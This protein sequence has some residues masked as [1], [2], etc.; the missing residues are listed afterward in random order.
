[1]TG[2]KQIVG[3]DLG[4][5][6]SALAV[7]DE[8]GVPRIVPN[9]E[10]DKLTPS[11]VYFGDDEI[12]VGKGA[13]HEALN[14]PKQAVRFVKREMGEQFTIY[15]HRNTRYYP[16]D[17]SAEILKKLKQDAELSLGFP[18][19]DAVI[20]V[21]AYFDEARR[22]ATKEAGQKAGLNVARL[23][24][25]PTAAALAFGFARQEA[26][27]QNILVYDLG[28]GTFDVTLISIAGKQVQ[29]LAVE[30]EHELGG[31]DFDNEILKHIIGIFRKKYGFDPIEDS[32]IEI[33]LRER[34]EQ[35]KKM[36][37]VQQQV[38]ILVRARG[39]SLR[40]KLTQVEFTAMIDH[41]LKASLMRVEM[42]LEA[43]NLNKSNVNEVLLVGGSTR[44]PAIANML[45]EYFGKPPLRSVNP[46]EAVAYGA[47][48]AG[49]L[50]MM[51]VED[52]QA[53]LSLT[54][55]E[56]LKPASFSDVIPYTFGVVIR[57]RNTNQL[58]NSILIDKNSSIPISQA[59]D[60]QTIKDNQQAV[61]ITVLQGD[62]PDP[63][64]CQVLGEFLLEGLPPGRPAGRPIEITYTCNRDGII[65][66]HA[67]D[68]DTGLQLQTSVSY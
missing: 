57:D 44:I 38:S 8:Y 50:E 59:G 64:D 36:L 61:E 12:L 51:E 33:E 2:H 42:V 47:A 4:T 68:I 9:A 10:G 37:S 26:N 22:R 43:A 63:N 29:V 52:L 66:V 39:N 49:A 32:E 58:F 55:T 17:V 48:L 16:E 34:V 19:Q 27:R 1:M 18:V 54:A 13:L 35:A 53:G 25:E 11:V 23:I 28:G 24:S 62:S 7:V 14:S 60:Y 30:G 56:R 21:P 3:I 31:L 40:M 5:T 46:D 67:R 45:Q 15:R 6:L 20:S 65:E 41:F